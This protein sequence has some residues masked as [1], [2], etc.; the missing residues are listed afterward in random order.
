MKIN[1]RGND[2]PY[3]QIMIKFLWSDSMNIHLTSIWFQQNDATHHF[4]NDKIDLFRRKYPPEIPKIR[5][6]DHPIRQHF[7]MCD[8]E[9]WLC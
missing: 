2:D 9:A 3:R 8:I 4:T 7:L 1:V 5:C 6:P